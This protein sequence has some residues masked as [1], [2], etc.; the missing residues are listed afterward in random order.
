[1]PNTPVTR[2]CGDESPAATAPDALLDPRSCAAYLKVSVLTLAD[3]RTKGIGPDYLK[4]G[5]AVRYRRSEV[6]AWLNLYKKPAKR[7]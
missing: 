7:V 6:D 5:A 3:W 2:N 1:M 4:L